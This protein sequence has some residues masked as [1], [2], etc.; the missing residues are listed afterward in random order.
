MITKLLPRSATGFIKR[1]LYKN[2]FSISQMGQDYWIY[3]EAF[4]EKEGGYF[5]DI[6]AH[7]GITTS[8]TYLLEMRYKWSGICVE[9]NPLTFAKLKE[10]RRVQCLNVCLD[11][12]EG[13]VNFTLRDVFGGIVDE[14]LDNSSLNKISS[15]KIIKLKTV[16]LLSIL[17]EHQAPNI[18]D[19]L[20]I[21][22]E[23]SEE[24]ILGDFNFQ[25]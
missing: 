10:N 14:N 16:P 12:S 1:F 2:S 11:S 3:G 21:D 15:D 23:G 8:N 22:V 9:A 7:D 4:N 5:L 20:S 25:E 17:K 19:Y 24:R 13:E 6:G 18:I